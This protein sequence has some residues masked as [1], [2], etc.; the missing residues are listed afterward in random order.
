[1][2][3]PSLNDINAFISVASCRSFRGAADVLGVSHSAISLSM[4]NLESILGV[5][6]LNRTTRSVSLTQEGQRF[7]ERVI[8]VVSELRSV[9]EDVSAENG[10]PSGVVR[11][12]GSDGAIRVLLEAVV[13]RFQLLYPYVELDLVSE[14]ALVDIVGLGFDAGYDW[15]N[16]FLKT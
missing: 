2:K 9:L 16:R 5:R 7:L 8:P 15:Q 10:R 4:R 13:P 14:G 1:M 12:N 11:I 3:Q 6:L